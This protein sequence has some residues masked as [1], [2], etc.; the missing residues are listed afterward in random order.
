MIHILTINWTNKDGSIVEIIRGIE[1]G[2]KDTCRFT[3]CFQV[4][5]KKQDSDY[6]VA[7]WNVT[8]GY[9]L[10]SR[11]TG[12]KYGLGNIPTKKLLRYINSA[13]PDIV[14]IHCPN[15]YSINLF[16]LF[17]FLKK[18]NIPTIITN[19]AEFFYTGNCPHAFDCEQYKTG[20]KKCTR[21]FDPVHP[22]LINR[23]AYE[24]KRMK[25]A[26]E[27]AD[28]FVM[29][30][31][32]GWE[33]DRIESSPIAKDIPVKLIE[34]GVDT[35]IFCIKDSSLSVQGESFKHVVTHVTSQFSLEK[36]HPKGGY[37]LVKLAEQM[38]D[39]LFLVLGPYVERKEDILPANIRLIGHV[40]KEALSEYYN[41]SDV[42][43][44]TSRRETF[45]MASAESLCCGTP[46]AAFKAGGTESV[47]IPEWSRFAEFGDVEGLKGC[48]SE[49]VDLKKTKSDQISEEARNKYSEHIMVE[50]FYKLYQKLL[51]T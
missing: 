7:S 13:N 25:Q 35:D 31:V 22:Y 10:L 29:T 19:H 1:E 37:Y 38:P 14:H 39:T 50:R 17:S 46:V 45:G 27:N 5:E 12:I 15:F 34:N 33:K 48:I 47:A 44:L 18:K 8:R 23:T 2:L 6:R 11:I 21:Q 42:T 43:V 9:Y 24:W 41:I 16:M 28:H 32:S 3:H 51:E 26:F 40:D 30:V 36:D 49:L 4:G 20:C